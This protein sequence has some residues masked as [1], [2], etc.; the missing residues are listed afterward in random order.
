[1][2]IIG[3]LLKIAEDIEP[4]KSARIA[5]AVVIKNKI[6]SYGTNSMNSHPFQ[7]KYGKNSHAVF[8]HA[9]TNAIFNALKRISI[10]DFTKATLYVVRVKLDGH[11]GK[12]V[13][14][15]A[16]PCDGCMKCIQKFRVKKIMYSTE[17][18][19]VHT[20]V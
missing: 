8:W 19:M 5:A 16:H 3:N 6:I 9:E 12:F 15:L 17:S 1:M 7:S 10:N 4:I 14:G 18:G 11:K 2:D 20:T 13:T